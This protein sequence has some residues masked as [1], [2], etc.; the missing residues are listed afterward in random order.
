MEAMC[1]NLAEQVPHPE[2]EPNLDSDD[3]A[4]WVSPLSTA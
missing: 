2:K 1:S 3:A 4:E